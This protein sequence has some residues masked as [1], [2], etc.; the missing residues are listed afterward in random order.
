MSFNPM[1]SSTVF[2]RVGILTVKASVYC[3]V[4]LIRNC[5]HR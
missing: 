1:G 2:E 5:D 4:G 3:G